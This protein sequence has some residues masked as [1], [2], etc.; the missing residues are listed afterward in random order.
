MMT[1]LRSV[2]LADAFVGWFASG[3]MRPI[4]IEPGPPP[5]IEGVSIGL[6]QMSA[7]PPHNGER[8]SDGDELLIVIAG[9]VRVRLDDEPAESLEVGPGQ[10]C[11]VPKGRWH[12]VQPLEPTR[13]IH[14]T[15]GPN[16]GH[17]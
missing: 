13:L 8:H 17:R 14:V 2:D 15:P 7:P 9:R 12:R 5:N 11:I 16:N 1:G 10:A 4:A 6:A 3:E